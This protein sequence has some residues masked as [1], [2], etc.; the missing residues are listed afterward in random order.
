MRNENRAGRIGIVLGLIGLALGITA[1]CISLFTLQRVLDREGSDVASV[2]SLIEC[3]CGALFTTEDSLR[4]HQL[5]NGSEEHGAYKRLP[6]GA[7]EGDLTQ[8]GN[9]AN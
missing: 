3:E 4:A 7:F 2:E 5:A 9:E 8:R 6:L 1:L